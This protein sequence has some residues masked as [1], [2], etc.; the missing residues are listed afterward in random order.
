[1]D[2]IAVTDTSF[3]Q[4]G[5]NPVRESYIPR[6]LSA[7]CAQ[8]IILTTT[9][10]LPLAPL[11][12]IYV[13]DGEQDAD[14]EIAA[15]KFVESDSFRLAAGPAGFVGH[16]APLIDLPRTAPPNLP[17][18]RRVLVVNGSHSDVS[19]GQV[20]HA[21]H[22]GWAAGSV[23]ELAGAKEEPGWVI[24]DQPVSNCSPV[25]FAQ[26]LSNTVESILCHKEFEVVLVSGGDTA[27]AILDLLG[28]ADIRPIGGVLEGVPIS[29]VP[30][31][32]ARLKGNGPLYLISKA[33]GFGPVDVLSLIKAKLTRG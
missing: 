30:R 27:Y 29:A 24:L 9:T 17:I 11:A 22:H 4:D 10:N 31:N 5:L 23:D 2:G 15:R 26:R 12:G 20:Q 3:A 7:E 25:E 8:R 32:S 14:L 21:R 18:L 16:V 1:M 6:L 28:I 19:T 13:C 33:G